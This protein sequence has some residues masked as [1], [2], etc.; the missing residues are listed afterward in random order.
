MSGSALTPHRH[1]GMYIHTYVHAGSVRLYSVVFR[2]SSVLP[3][4]Q[5]LPLTPPSPSSPPHR[6]A[7]CR[8]S[9]QCM[10][11]TL[12]ETRSAAV[13]QWGSSPQTSWQQQPG[14][15]CVAHRHTTG[16]LL[17]GKQQR[18]GGEW[19]G[20]AMCGRSYAP[21]VGTVR[22]WAQGTL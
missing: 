21:L 10:S 5:S 17:R 7:D 1:V 22:T 6:T 4:P 16:T 11:R 20:S 19:V 12:L 2:V 18:E 3:H 15:H 8:R 13:D 9:S 14:K